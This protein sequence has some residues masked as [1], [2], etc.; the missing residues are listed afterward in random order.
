MHLSRTALAVAAAAT[1]AAGCASSTKAAGGSGAAPTGGA[2]TTLGIL[3]DF[4]GLSASGN[5]TSNLGVAAGIY[6]AGLEGVHF[7]YVE[8]DTQTSPTG[9][10][11]AAKELVEQDHVSAVVAVSALTFLAAGYLKQQDVPV[12]GV[13]EDGGEWVTDPNMFSTYGFLDPK[14]VSTGDGEFFK[15]EGATTIGALGYGISPQSAQA[16]KNVIASAQAVGL[17]AGYLNAQ[18]PYGS[19]NVAPIAIAMKNAGVDGVSSETDPNTTFALIQALRQVGDDLKV[20]VVPDGYGGDLSQAGPGA[21]EIGQGVYFTLSFEPV[22]MHTPATE[23]FQQALAHVGVTGDPTYAEYAGYTSIAL[24]TQAI[25][26]TGPNPTHRALI[27]ALSHITDFNAWGL[28]GNHPLNMSDR[29]AS[30]IGP[31]GCGYYTKLEGTTFHLVP[32]ADPLCGTLVPG[33]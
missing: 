20:A 8:G 17:K 14:A 4:S 2:V 32:G 30:A 25:K 3:G 12:V 7:K 21:A 1:L 13:A 29:A 6:E 19:T 23:Q 33:T 15:M 11:T 28:L 9:A 18:F 22:E 16:A 27:S 24:L 10:Q 5:K 26:M 31:D